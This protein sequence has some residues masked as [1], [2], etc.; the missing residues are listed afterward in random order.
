MNF[1]E[2]S[3]PNEVP[4][5]RKDAGIPTVRSSRGGALR[6]RA[7]RNYPTANVQTGRQF[8]AAQL[9]PSN[10]SSTPSNSTAFRTFQEHSQAYKRPYNRSHDMA[11]F[12]RQR[13]D[14]IPENSRRHIGLSPSHL[15]KSR[16]KAKRTDILVDLPLHCRKGV[17][18]N[19][20]SRRQWIDL[21]IQRLQKDREVK[22]H[23]HAVL[24]CAVRFFCVM[25]QNYLPR[26][27]S[28]ICDT[29]P[30]LLPNTS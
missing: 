4:L 3:Q 19:Q 8:N 13:I 29:F 10:S 18:G 16:V 30:C 1:S 21:E 15:A 14:H 2:D 9:E 5:A 7:R 6:A 27:T 28:T 25:H 11:H 20:T 12:R 23:G 22:I 17:P 24:D 26:V